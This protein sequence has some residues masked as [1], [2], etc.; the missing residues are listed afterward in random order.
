LQDDP[1]NRSSNELRH[2]LHVATDKLLVKH[3]ARR[4]GGAIE[5]TTGYGFL[6]LLNGLFVDSS[7]KR[8]FQRLHRQFT[9]WSQS[10]ADLIYESKRLVMQ[11]SM[12]SELNVLSRRLDRISEHHRRSPACTPECRRDALREVIACFP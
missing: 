5:G 6:N 9:G 3:E 1:A 7:S 4:P 2:N 11:E 12:S 10:Y 8:V